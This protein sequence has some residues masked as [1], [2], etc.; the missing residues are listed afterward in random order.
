MNHL[1]AYDVGTSGAK[2]VLTT[3]EGRVVATAFAPYPTLYPRPTWAHQGP[4][5]W[6]RAVGETTQHVLHAGGAK[7]ESVAG[8]AFSTQMLNVVC[9]DR[10]QEPIGPAIS[11]LDGRAGAEAAWVM[12]RLGGPRAFA[13]IVGAALTG[14]DLLPKYLWIKRHAP[15]VYAQTASFVDASGYLL[16]RTTG[17]LAY[18]WTCASVTG[19]FSLKSKKWDGMLMRL[20]GLDAAKF[21]ETAPSAA[22]IG[23]LTA[24]AAAH[25]GLTEG[26]PVFGG[27]GDAMTAAV[28]SGALGEGEGHLCLGTSGFVGIMTAR[29]VTGRRGMATV[30]SADPDKLLLVGVNETSAECLRWAAR[31]LYGADDADPSIYPKMDAEVAASAPGAGGLIFTPWLYGERCPIA[32]ERLRAGFINLGAN[33]TRAQMTRAIYEGVAYNVRWV[34]E[35]M[36]ELYRFRPAALRAVGG[37]ARGLPWLQIIADVSGRALEVV[38]NPHH[39]G[40][41]GAALLAAVGLGIYPSVPAIERVVQ[42]THVIAPNPGARAVYDPLYAAFQ[43]IY[44]A[45]RAVYGKL[46]APPPPAVP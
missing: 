18:E 45:L 3:T 29:R 7:P 36:D 38:E 25:L 35:S 15:D 9:L 33:H 31:E 46:N 17:R 2:A 11:W 42:P 40:A 21:P 44:P 12:R 19:L 14:K 26:T 28:G 20:F 37:G 23:G 27:A 8:L 30:Q 39:A 43:E 24:A 5:D 4:A 34:L 6:W 16:H 13:M 32:D 22:R 41:V 10:Q 1:L